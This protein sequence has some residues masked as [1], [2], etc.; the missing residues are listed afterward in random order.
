MLA[1]VLGSLLLYFTERD[2]KA[3]EL[4]Q[5]AAS[6]GLVFPDLDPT[7]PSVV[8]SVLPCVGARLTGLLTLR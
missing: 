7:A 1:L 3:R 5:G 8:G 2:V 6:I 4:S